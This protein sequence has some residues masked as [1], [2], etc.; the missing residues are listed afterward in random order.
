MYSSVIVC[1]CTKNSANYIYKHLQL[2]YD[3]SPLFKKFKMI[4]YENDSTDNTVEILEQ[5]KKTHPKFDYISEKLN[6]KNEKIPRT[7]VLAHGRNTLLKHIQGYEYMIMSDLDDV[8]ATFKPS[9]LKYFFEHKHWDALF[10]NCETYYD[11]WALRIKDKWTPSCPFE[12]IDYDCWEKA[13]E[14]K[15]KYFINRHQIK[16]SK[17]SS[18]IPVDSAFGG[19]GIYRVNKIKN[20]YNGFGGKRCEHVEFHKGMKR[21]FICPK[22]LVNNQDQHTKNTKRNLFTYFI[23]LVSYIKRYLSFVINYFKNM[24]IV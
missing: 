4:V 10:A 12:M 3:M 22:F 16:I 11:I 1:G 8:I 21:L 5:F 13:H 2:L 18:L 17:K 19:F 6:K 14:Y 7:V 23:Y 9:Q 24:N 15:T 20:K